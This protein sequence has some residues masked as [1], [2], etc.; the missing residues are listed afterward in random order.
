MHES[1]NNIRPVFYS[2]KLNTLRDEILP[3]IK[4]YPKR[5]DIM[6]VFSMNINE[7]KVVLLGQDPYFTPDT[8]IGYAFAVNENGKIPPSLRVIRQELDNSYE[9]TDWGNKY[10]LGKDLPVWKTLKHWTNQGVFLLNA[11]LTVEAGIAGSHS[12]YWLDFT[13][14]VIKYISFKRNCIWL[15]WGNNAKKFIPYIYRGL[16]VSEYKDSIEDI[17]LDRNYILEAPHPAASLYGGKNSFVGCN[18]FNITNKILKI[19][20]QKQI[21]W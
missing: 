5:E 12:D 20:K 9:N 21:M 17:P 2:D 11:A 13:K 15:I 3:N 8:A 18:H 19:N 10:L 16:K 4:Y 14:E 6:N 1:W 7:I